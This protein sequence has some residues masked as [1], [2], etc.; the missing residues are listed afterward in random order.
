MSS[1]KN[2]RIE[3]IDLNKPHTCEFCNKSFSREGTLVAHV[4][5]PKRRHLV[6]KEPHVRRAHVAFQLFHNSITPNKMSIKTYQEFSS[7]SLY[8][9]FVKFGSWSLENQ[10]QEFSCLVDYLLKNNIKVDRWCDLN[11]YK[12]YLSNL[13]DNEKSEQAIKR[14]LETIFNWG[15]DTG[16]DWTSFFKSCHPNVITN[17]FKDGRISPWLLYNAPSAVNYFERCSPEQLVLIQ[18]TASIRKWKVRFLRMK[19]ESDAIQE[20]LMAAGV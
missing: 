10:V 20:C 17:W 6:Q 1:K 9:A 18:E 16:N 12:E 15:R 5:E 8:G 7:S 3:V 4:C 14:S 2:S 13:L 19:Q 11:I